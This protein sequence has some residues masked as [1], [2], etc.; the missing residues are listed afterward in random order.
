MMIVFGFSFN[1]L[2]RVQFH[3]FLFLNGESISFNSLCR[4]LYKAFISQL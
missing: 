3:P 4:V 2:C 1:S